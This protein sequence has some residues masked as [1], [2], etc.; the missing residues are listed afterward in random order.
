MSSPIPAPTPECYLLAHSI[1]TDARSAL[2]YSSLAIADGATGL[3]HALVKLGRQANVTTIAGAADEAER[4]SLS[5]L[6][7]T[8]VIQGDFQAFVR[9]VMD[10]TLGNGA[11]VIIDQQAGAGFRRQF[12]MIAD[13]GNVLVTGWSAG[14]PPALFATL[15]AALDRCPCVQIWTLDRYRNRRD[16]LDILERDLRSLLEQR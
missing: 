9:G 16:R 7:A 10:Y 15:W 8:H 2:G 1:L 13:F 6:G 11:E 14:D 3:G 5:V 4:S 12:E